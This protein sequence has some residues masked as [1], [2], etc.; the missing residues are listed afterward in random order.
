MRVDTIV[1]TFMQGWLS[2][3]GFAA[4]G[5]EHRDAP[6]L[7]APAAG[8]AGPS[9]PAK[10]AAAVMRP[11]PAS[12]PPS[13]SSGSP[14]ISQEVADLQGGESGRSKPPRSSP[15]MRLEAQVAVLTKPPRD[16]VSVTNEG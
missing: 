13:A 9:Q 10:T 4:D 16:P 3:L 11:C 2:C 15:T 1:L 6:I 8:T 12:N 5:D 7:Q 14:L